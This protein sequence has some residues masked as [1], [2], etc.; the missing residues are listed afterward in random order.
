MSP[1]VTGGRS[2]YATLPNLGNAPA[3]TALL[4]DA[5]VAL[6]VLLGLKMPA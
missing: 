6:H 3:F 1:S 2:F 4:R 5:V